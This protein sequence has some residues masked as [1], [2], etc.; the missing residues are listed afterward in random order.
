MGAPS[1][2]EFMR[3][4][5]RE[6]LAKCVEKMRAATPGIVVED[7]AGNL[8][9]V[10]G[11]IIR[12]LQHQAGLPV[13]SPL[14]GKSET[15]SRHGG[16]AQ[17]RGIPIPLIAM[18]F[19][20]I[21]DCTGELGAREGLSF[22]ARQYQVFNLCIDTA[23]AS[24]LE[25]YWNLAEQ[26]LR[27]EAT[28]RMAFLA[29]ELRNSLQSARM[30]FAILSQAQIGVKSKTGQILERNLGRIDGLVTQ[31]LMAAQLQSGVKPVLKPMK[32]L[33]LLQEL[34]E[35]AVTERDIV[36]A[37]EGNPVEVQADERLLHSAVSN[38]VQNAIKFSRAGGRVVLRTRREAGSVVIEVQDQC[39]GLPPGDP[40]NL[41]KPHVQ[42]SE[43]R[44]GFGLGLSITR[45]AIEAHGGRLS[46]RDLPGD[47]CVFEARL[48]SG[49]MEDTSLA[50]A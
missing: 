20:A 17:R 39:G 7:L 33:D 8:D 35:S 5:R 3:E 25:R 31:T 38:L 23:I 34:Q 19:G 44:R 10:I 15:A 46:V 50:T 42:S 24:G 16:S 30:A 18:H 40:E 32:L 6:L 14:P 49:V 28:G 12:A 48:P 37:V 47:G 43:D 21:S 26:E 41:F 11:E 1:L 27:S 2:H 45:E 4:N 13:D 9:G 29:H 36:L 22:T